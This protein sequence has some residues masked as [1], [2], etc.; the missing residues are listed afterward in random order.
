MV[1]QM[2]WR[3]ALI[4]VYREAGEP[5]DANQA[6]ERIAALGLRDFSNAATPERT[7][8]RDLLNMSREAGALLVRAAPGV[9]EYHDPDDPSPE[10]LEA[11]DQKLD[12]PESPEEPQ[13]IKVTACGLYWTKDA[14]TWGRGCKIMGQQVEGSARID[15]SE[16]QGV[17]LLYRGNSIVY[18]GRTTDSLRA[19][20]KD[21]ASRKNKSFRWDHFSWF[22]FRPVDDN[23]TLGGLP[24]GIQAADM[25]GVLET[26][27]IEALEP[28]ING[29]RGDHM[30]EHYIQVINQ[31]EAGRRR[32]RSLQALI[33]L[34]QENMK[35]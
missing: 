28:P 19:R 21:H 35:N 2:S 6:V 5:I 9:Y 17:Y 34:A 13:R 4:H 29:M 3:Q 15:F 30:G 25:I 32:I 11:G 12:G 7:A 26:V 24:E 27:L 8:S 31:E 20:L 16:Q 22:G 1:N 14:V 23:G 10:E 33:E 18:V